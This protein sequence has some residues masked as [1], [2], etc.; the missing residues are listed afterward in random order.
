MNAVRHPAWMCVVLLAGVAS[1]WGIGGFYNRVDSGPTSAGPPQGPPLPPGPLPNRG[2]SL[3]VSDQTRHDWQASLE[4]AADCRKLVESLRATPRHDHPLFASALRDYALRRWLEL[5]PEDALSF[6]EKAGGRWYESTLAGDLF[7]LWVGLDADSA[8]QAFAQ[9]SPATVM[10]ARRDF[11]TKLAEN[12]PRRAVEEME[13]PRWRTAA[14]IVNPEWEQTGLAVY[15]LWAEKEPQA[16][17]ERLQKINAGQYR[18]VLAAVAET[19]ARRDPEAAWEFFKPEPGKPDRQGV[20][21]AILP[22]LLKI[23]PAAM[24]RAPE[25]VTADLAEFWSG[26]NP[27]DAIAFAQTR[28]VDD[29]LRRELFTHAARI[30]ATAE[31]ERAIQLYRDSAGGSTKAWVSSGVLREA[32]ASLAGRDRDQAISKLLEFSGKDREAAMSGVFTQAFASDIAD[33]SALARKWLDDPSLKPAVIPSLNVALSWG[34]GGGNHDLG[35][36]LERMPEL[37]EHL[38]GHPLQG[39]TRTDP[40]AAAAFLGAQVAANPNLSLGDFEESLRATAEGR[41]TSPL[42]P[43]ADLE[44]VTEICFSRPE[45]TA[46]WLN[47]LPAGSFQTTTAGTLART[48]SRFDPEA[49]NDWA[50]SLPEGPPK[51]AALEALGKSSPR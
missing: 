42:F 31:P 3:P 2:V 13:S 46:E 1:G 6:A 21:A 35:P 40:E 38:S 12:D 28:P 30:L 24:D 43:M 32:F 7:R 44:A 45:F 33:A 48:W 41:T 29:P 51:E 34:H 20:A 14:R 37:A 22:Y 47:R 19:W 25:G 5:D 23:N 11:F 26:R 39:W 36:I 4:T 16:A 17:A 10:A 27:E 8:L 18:G 50:H 49:A 9:A 15:T